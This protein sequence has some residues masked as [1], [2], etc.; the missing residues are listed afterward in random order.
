MYQKVNSKKEKQSK[1][2]SLKEKIMGN[3]LALHPQ[4]GQIYMLHLWKKGNG[5]WHTRWTLYPK[6]S[7][8]ISSILPRR[9][10]SR[11]MLQLQHKPRRKSVGIRSKVR[12]RESETVVLIKGDHYEILRKGLRRKN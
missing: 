1:N 9:K 8:G 11:S 2:L 3:L 12:A 10:R 4:S 5:R 7:R 6:S